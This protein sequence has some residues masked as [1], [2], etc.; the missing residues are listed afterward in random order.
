[1]PTG[2]GPHPCPPGAGLAIDARTHVAY[3]T[4]DTVHSNMPANSLF[5]FIDG[6]DTYCCYVPD[7]YILEIH[8]ARSQVPVSWVLSQ[9]MLS[10]DG[11][12]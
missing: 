5:V 7:V 12:V 9:C 4:T 8:I 10:V 2:V 3:L 1:M 11:C 6:T